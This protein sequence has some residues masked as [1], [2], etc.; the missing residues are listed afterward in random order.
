MYNTDNIVEAILADHTN[1]S[2]ELKTK[3]SQHK[4]NLNHGMSSWTSVQSENNLTV[5]TG[6][7][8]DWLEHLKTPIIN[9]DN[10]SNI[11]IYSSKPQLLSLIH[12]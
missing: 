10:L 2:E 9:Q 11:V 6:L 5:L 4:V 8:M 12:I 1:I 7:L 3:I